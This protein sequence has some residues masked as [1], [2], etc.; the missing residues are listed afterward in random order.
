MRTC[1]TEVRTVE[2]DFSVGE[3]LV[4]PRLNTVVR[5]GK[6]THI[7]PKVM[8]VLVYL[9]EHPGEVVS[10]DEILKA[11]WGDTFVTENALTRCITELRRVF[12]DDVRAPHVIQTIAKSGYRLIADIHKIA[13]KGSELSPAGDAVSLRPGAATAAPD[14]A[15]L[16]SRVFM[17]LGI[18]ALVGGAISGLVVWNLRTTPLPSPR[19]STRFVIS[20][21]TELAGLPIARQHR[22]AATGGLAIALAPDNTHLV[23]A[24]ANQAGQS[25][26][27]L[28]TMDKLEATPIQGTEDGFGPFF[29]PDGSTLGFFAAGKLKK[30]SLHGGTP[31]V[32]CDAPKSFGATWVPDDTIIFA[33]GGDAGLV[34]I[35]AAG[36]TPQLL[37]TPD[38]LKGE[39]SYVWPEVLPGGKSVIFTVRLSGSANEH[40]QIGVRSLETGHQ[41][42]LLKNATGARYAAANADPGA[43]GFLVFTRAPDMVGLSGRHGATLWAVPFDT[44]SLELA[45]ASPMPVAEGVMVTYWGV[46]QVSFSPRGGLVYIQGEHAV[47]SRLMWVDRRGATEPLPLPARIY[48]HP[49]LSPDGRSIAVGIGSDIWVSDLARGTLNRLTLEHKNYWPL[50]THDGNRVAYASNRDGPMNLFWIKADG[51]GG[52]ER[53]TKEQNCSPVSFSRDG[54]WLAFYE[55][56]FNFGGNY[57]IWLLPLDGERKPRRLLSAP[58]VERS[59]VFSPDGQWLAYASDE[60][61]RLE[62]YVQP[63]PGPGRKWPIS[64]EGGREPLWSRNGELFYRM[65][66]KMM[67]VDVKTSPMFSAGKP[68]VLFEGR[69]QDG[70]HANYDVTPDGQRFLMVAEPEPAPTQL[71]VVLEWFEGLKRRTRPAQR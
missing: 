39:G 66:D 60:S 18:G 14:R 20:L 57:D 33:P 65:G 53:L 44:Q 2:G 51:S 16:Y 36:G 49:G 71:H 50:W 29:S 30:V 22:S 10:K 42:V 21:P 67:A 12:D 4:Q 62:I 64:N 1:P 55:F 43:P 56:P 11:I 28:R 37:A 32:L 6:T 68:K 19:P 3:C 8:E 23:Y 35:S 5:S 48:N 27:Y 52:E 54:K 7:E 26:L 34:R 13:G 38:P 70:G 61:G 69:Y 9:A 47:A 63:F 24:L 40:N 17:L 46:A 25:Q 31:V 41:T 58:F 15:G 45:N 59:P